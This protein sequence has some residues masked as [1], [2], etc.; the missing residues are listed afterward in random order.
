MDQEVSGHAAD[1]LEQ[2]QHTDRLSL[3]SLYALVARVSFHTRSDGADE[4]VATRDP[5]FPEL[6]Q[7]LFHPSL[8]PRPDIVPEADGLA[9]RLPADHVDGGGEGS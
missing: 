8:H 2:V 6:C 4:E 7:L 5:S 3:V 9:L 1:V